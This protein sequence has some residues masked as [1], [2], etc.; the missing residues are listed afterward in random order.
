MEDGTDHR[1]CIIYR[2]GHWRVLD[3][4]SG[5]LHLDYEGD[6]E[7]S[8]MCCAELDK[9]KHNVDDHV[10]EGHRKILDII[11]SLNH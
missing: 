1:S 8:S 11:S 9:G 4:E 3:L 10:K 2:N 7:H 5:P 6:F